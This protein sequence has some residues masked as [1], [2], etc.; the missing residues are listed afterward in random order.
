MNLYPAHIEEKIGF[1]QIREYLLEGCLTIVGR[2]RVETL[3]VFTEED[4]IRE[5]MGYS[6]ELR[7]LLEQGNRPPETEFEPT[8][9]A[10]Q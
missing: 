8:D 2:E 6:S 4:R 10:I 5:E 7:G 1:V 9:E 3:Q